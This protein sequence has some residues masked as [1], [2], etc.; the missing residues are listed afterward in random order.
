M[1]NVC[2]VQSLVTCKN[3]YYEKIYFAVLFC[4]VV[5]V[6]EYSK[7]ANQWWSLKIDVPGAATLSVL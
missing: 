1:K 7:V 3:C 5:N 2:I 4:S 6:S